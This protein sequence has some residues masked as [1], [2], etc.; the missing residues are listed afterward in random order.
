M[1]NK[2]RILIEEMTKSLKIDISTTF[3]HLKIFGFVF[4]FGTEQVLT[5]LCGDFSAVTKRNGAVF[6]Q[7]G[8]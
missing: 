6:E 2:A 4:K 7:N 8:Q 5:Y 1:G 3:H